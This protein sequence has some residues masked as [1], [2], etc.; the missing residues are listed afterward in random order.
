MIEWLKGIVLTNCASAKLSAFFVSAY[1]ALPPWYWQR[2]LSIKWK[3][4]YCELSTLWYLSAGMFTAAEWCQLPKEH[5]FQF[6][7]LKQAYATQ[8]NVNNNFYIYFTY[9]TRAL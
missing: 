9:Q 2:L 1:K 4:L 6:E 3:G 8:K 5:D 7:Y